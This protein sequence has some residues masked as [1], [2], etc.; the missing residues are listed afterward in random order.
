MKTATYCNSS[1]AC[2]S[3]TKMAGR[4]VEDRGSW[5][6]VPFPGSLIGGD[7]FLLLF[8]PHCSSLPWAQM[9]RE[10]ASDIPTG[11]TECPPH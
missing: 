2:F 5:S 6:S 10:D 9:Y 11:R 8:S 3:V 1:S 7:S 4:H